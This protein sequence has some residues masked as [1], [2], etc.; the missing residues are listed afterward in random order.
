M[1][2]VKEYIL[3]TISCCFPFISKDKIEV[4]RPKNNKWGDYTS[5]VCI[6]HF[7]II[8]ENTNVKTP[9]EASEL[10]KNRILEIW[11]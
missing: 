9:L 7:G 10:L 4:Y 11:K 3:E 8:K 6:K 1:E 2:N 5:N